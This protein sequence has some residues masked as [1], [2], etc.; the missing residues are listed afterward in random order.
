[1]A[2]L[3]KREYLEVSYLNYKQMRIRVLKSK[4]FDYK[5]KSIP[6]P[7]KDTLPAI[8]G[9]YV[10][11]NMADKPAKYGGFKQR[12]KERRIESKAEEEA[13]A[14]TD[15]VRLAFEA[16]WSEPFGPAGFRVE[17]KEQ[18][19]HMNGGGFVG[20]MEKTIVN[21]QAKSIKVPGIFFTLKRAAEKIEVNSKFKV[22]PL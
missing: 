8:N 11:P 12:Y 17:W 16:I 22:T 13:A 3:I 1:M 2:L 21:C 10:P 5:Q 15:A 14:A 4:K 19:E 9:G 18:Y 20:A 7:V 6:F